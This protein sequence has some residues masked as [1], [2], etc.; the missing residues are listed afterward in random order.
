MQARA[1]AKQRIAELE[2]KR[3][4]IEENLTALMVILNSKTEA[5]GAAPGLRGHLNDAEGFPRAD[6]DHY[7]V[8]AQRKKVNCL[9]TDLVEINQEI[10]RAVLVAMPAQHDNHSDSSSAP[11]GVEGTTHWRDVLAKY[12]NSADSSDRSGEISKRHS[13]SDENSASATNDVDDAAVA[14]EST[15]KVLPTAAVAFA[16][17]DDISPT[18][19]ATA[20]GL[21]LGDKLLS[22]GR[23]NHANHNNLRVVAEEAQRQVPL[24]VVVERGGQI[25]EL[26]LLP[27]PWS[28]RGLIGCHILPL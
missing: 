13:S 11:K 7:A 16:V 10:E 23:A 20:A 18:S 14:S 6:I 26:Q 1:A 21:R 4:N 22:F 3:K 28:G 8:K 19:P 5:G 27:Q 12:S 17:I 24:K 2:A 9:R 25:V 15:P